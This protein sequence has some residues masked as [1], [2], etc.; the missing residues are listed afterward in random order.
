MKLK[1]KIKSKV[2]G[3]D[4]YDLRIVEI[5][6]DSLT[7]DRKPHRSKLIPKT[8]YYDEVIKLTGAAGLTSS[9]IN[10]GRE[11]RI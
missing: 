2:D 10:I 6:I 5:L 9:D 7:G 3:L 4:P 8:N 1:E 11:E